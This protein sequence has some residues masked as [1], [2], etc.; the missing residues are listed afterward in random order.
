MTRR[1]PGPAEGRAAGSPCQWPAVT[2]GSLGLGHM[3]HLWHQGPTE[4]GEAFMFTDCE[5]S[6]TPGNLNPARGAPAGRGSGSN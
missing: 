2:G 5:K 3:I 6:A 4:T 1:A